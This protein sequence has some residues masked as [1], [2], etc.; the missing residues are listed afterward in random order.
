MQSYKKNLL[1][2]GWIFRAEVI[3]KDEAQRALM[4]W[5]VAKEH[6]NTHR[7]TCL[8]V[9]GSFVC[10]LVNI[11][12]FVLPW[13]GSSLSSVC[14]R[15]LHCCTG[16]LLKELP[17]FL[18]TYLYLP[19]RITD[20]NPLERPFLILKYSQEFTGG[21]HTS[22]MLSV[23]HAFIFQMTSLIPDRKHQTDNKR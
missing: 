10:T 5:H 14:D 4:G 9:R 6:N 23:T 16:L 13:G 11:D 21:L 17:V 7:C 8:R 22:S 15:M 12:V 19:G 2:G 1:C 3:N 20:T 18:L